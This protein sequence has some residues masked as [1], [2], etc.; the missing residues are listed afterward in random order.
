MWV[1]WWLS[2]KESPCQ[3]RRLRF[4]PWLGRSPGE[5]NGNPS[6]ILDWEIPWT[7]EPGRLQSMLLQRVGRDWAHMHG[8]T[9]RELREREKHFFFLKK[10]EF[11]NWAYLT[12]KMFQLKKYVTR[13][14]QELVILYFPL[15]AKAQYSESVCM[16][17]I[18]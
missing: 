1:S 14:L 4:D 2:G 12:Q 18:L 7:E 3:C 17:S 6:N 11:D 10:Q 16:V 5:G 13:G 9:G 8:Y 15:G